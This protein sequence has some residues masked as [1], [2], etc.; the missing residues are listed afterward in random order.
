MGFFG[1][2]LGS[3][4]VNG[5]GLVNCKMGVEGAELKRIIFLLAN[6]DYVKRNQKECVIVKTDLKGEVALGHRM[7]VASRHVTEA[8]LARKHSWNGRNIHETTRFIEQDSRHM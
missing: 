4:D 6:I 7:A 5:D 1:S 3:R 2:V 8:V